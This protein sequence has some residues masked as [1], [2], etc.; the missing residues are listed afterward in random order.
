MGSVSDPELW[1]QV[2][3][4]DSDSG[5]RSGDTDHGLDHNNDAEEPDGEPSGDDG[6]GPDF[7]PGPWRAIIQR[8]T[9]E[10]AHTGRPRPG[11]PRDPLTYPPIQQDEMQG[12]YPGARVDLTPYSSYERL[13]RMIE[14]YNARLV[15]CEY[16][17]N[18]E[19]CEE[20]LKEI[21]YLEDIQA[22]ADD[23]RP[24]EMANLLPEA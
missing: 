7:A 11:G 21:Q 20:I 18:P 2:H 22:G 15:E 1:M 17:N 23:I 6:E 16:N 19:R 12:V 3:H 4:F 10:A 9:R 8:L 13:T 24:S 5:E 14:C